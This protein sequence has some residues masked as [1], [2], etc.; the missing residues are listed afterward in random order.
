MRGEIIGDDMDLLSLGLARHNFLQKSDKLRAGV[1]CARLAEDCTA[2]C[3]QG[4]VERKSAVAVVFKPVPFRPARGKRQDRI[5]TVEGLKG[6]LLI[7]AEDRGMGG[8]FEVKADNISRLGLEVWVIAQHVTAHPVGLQSGAA[9]GARHGRVARAKMPGESARAPVGRAIAR[10]LARGRQNARL[11]L[12][13][14][15][16]RFAPTVARSQSTQS[17]GEEALLPVVDIPIGA[18]ELPAN[19]AKA[20]PL[21]QEKNHFRSA[22]LFDRETPASAPP[23]QFFSFRRSQSKYRTLHT[24][25]YH[26]NAILVNDTLY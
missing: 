4:R 16:V 11:T 10:R 6:A 24:S 2:F 22:H 8:G 14:E 21:G 7:D 13:R 3:L 25:D 9:P 26:I 19:R 15:L 20:L 18:R 17:L 1:A 12:C 23:P 5:E